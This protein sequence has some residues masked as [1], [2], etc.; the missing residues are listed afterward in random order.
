[1][2]VAPIAS[3][4]AALTDDDLAALTAASA[5]ASGRSGGL[6]AYLEHAADWETLRRTGL[7]FPLREP[8][9]ALGEDERNYALAT[10][11]QL[12]GQCARQERPR[13]ADV[14]WA[15]AEALG[16]AARSAH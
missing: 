8:G 6:L 2:N 16:W 9:E 3:V 14:L 5:P 11:G 12:V 1:V 10:L 4:L 15:V 13:V 7:H